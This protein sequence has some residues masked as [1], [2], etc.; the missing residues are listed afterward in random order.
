MKQY[1]ETPT[2]SVP[3]A[4]ITI[5]V[6]PKGEDVNPVTKGAVVSAAPPPEPPPPP[7]PQPPNKTAANAAITNFVMLCCVIEFFAVNTLAANIEDNRHGL[8]YK[9][10][11]LPQIYQH[12]DSKFGVAAVVE[13]F[14]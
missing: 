9:C 1:A 7:P 10:C 3:V 8:D 13:S 5:A 6:F 12:N 2:L 4:V 11:A 14:P